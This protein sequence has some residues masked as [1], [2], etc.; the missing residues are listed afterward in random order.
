LLAPAAPQAGHCPIELFGG[1]QGKQY[2]MP[3]A[4]EAQELSDGTPN[5]LYVAMRYG[6]ARDTKIYVP[7]PAGDAAQPGIPAYGQVNADAMSNDLFTSTNANT[8]PP[9]FGVAMC[10]FADTRA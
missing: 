4:F 2:I 9:G 1:A 8:S 10:S 7:T 3:P 5:A 6:P